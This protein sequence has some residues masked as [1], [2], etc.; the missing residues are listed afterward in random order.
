MAIYNKIAGI[1]RSVWS[2]HVKVNN[3]WRDSDVYTNINGVWRETHRNT[4][5]YDDIIGF[6]FVYTFAKDKTHPNHPSLCATHNLPVTFNLTGDSIGNM[7]NHEKGVVL[8]YTSDYPFKEGIFAYDVHLYAELTDETLV[9]VG[10]A[11][12][13]GDVDNREVNNVSGNESWI[14]CRMVDLDINLVGY[15]MHESYGLYTAGWN[16]LFSTV[17]SIDRSTYPY[18]ESHKT[19]KQLEQ[20]QMLPIS[21]R[22][23]EFC[24]TGS[25]GIARDLHTMDFNMV[26]SHGS[27]SHTIT[28]VYLNGYEKPF[29]VEYYG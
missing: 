24:P 27:M 29:S 3:V 15:V 23:N 6:R 21:S 17:E 16:N 11:C 4:I 25:I 1:W 9:D 20:Y 13:P 8:I 14:S 19:I 10:L 26:G 12:A 22:S 2:S 18:G 5:Q 7:D 28:H